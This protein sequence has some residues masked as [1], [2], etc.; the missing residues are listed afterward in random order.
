MS[1]DVWGQLRGNGFSSSRAV[2]GVGSQTAS[3]QK[4]AE[5]LAEALNR[6]QTY[7]EYLLQVAEAGQVY[8]VVYALTQ[9]PDPKDNNNLHSC[10]LVVVGGQLL[11]LRNDTYKDQLTVGSVVRLIPDKGICGIAEPKDAPGLIVTLKRK[12]DEGHFEIDFNGLPK[13]VKYGSGVSPQEGDRAIVDPSGS[14]IIRVIGPDTQSYSINGSTGVTWDDIGGCEKAKAAMIEAIEL[15]IKHAD[16][17]RRY[18]KKAT[19]GVLLYGPPGT[20]KTLLGKAAATSISET[21]GGKG[22]DTNFIYVKGP[23]LLNKWVGNTE[24]SIRELFHRAREHKKKHGYAAILFI[25]E[26]DAL[27]GLRGENH[28]S[29]I[30][31]TVVPQFLSEMDGLED[32]GAM[33]LLS[34]NR[35]DSLDPAV[36]RDGRVN[37]KVRVERPSAKEASHIFK[38]HFR[39]V[40]LVAGLSQEEAINTCVGYLYNE[41]LSYYQFRLHDGSTRDFCLAHMVNGAMIAEIVNRATSRAIARD[42]QAN[43]SGS[44]VSADDL[45]K[46][47]VEVYVSNYDLNHKEA[48]RE[49]TAGWENEIKGAPERS[50]RYTFPS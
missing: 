45:M 6:I 2:N 35:P 39:D 44:G 34:T 41:M 33:V 10:A 20:G 5:A 38:I 17:Y 9:R 27:L 43:T 4:L 16:L 28:T 26:A 18:N 49:F 11:E 14:V 30:S 32:S 50:P 13:W 48:L 1:T 3:E 29:V 25:D 36:V 46:V 21:H 19:K 22:K 24:A 7:E 37:F 12:V 42:I 31:S 47:V 15:P 8:G 40:P 23:E